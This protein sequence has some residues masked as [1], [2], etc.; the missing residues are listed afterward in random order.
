MATKAL[1]AKVAEIRCNES[2]SEP[3]SNEKGRRPGGPRRF[4]E[5]SRRGP[6]L[7][8][9]MFVVI[10]IGGVAAAVAA[11]A[12]RLLIDTGHSRRR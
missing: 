3:V 4:D 5:T 1:S 10:A 7:I 11:Y 6:A 8:R 2:C 9:A 12:I